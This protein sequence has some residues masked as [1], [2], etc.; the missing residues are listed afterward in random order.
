[1]TSPTS[2]PSQRRQP[3]SAARS[4][5][6]RHWSDA[7]AI[8]VGVT[9]LA[10]SIWPGEPNASREASADLGNA[11]FAHIARLIAG[12]C[13]L[14]GV[15]LAQSPERRGLPRV[16]LVIGALSLLLAFGL[17][18]TDGTTGPR[19]WLSLALP[20]VLLFVASAGVGPLPRHLHD[21]APSDRNDAPSDLRPPVGRGAPDRR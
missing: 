12:A 21:D 4:P 19:A 7:L 20:A 14:L 2:S 6:T 15:G 3:G 18:L 1:M 11:Q 17:A 13:A 8:L 10:L 16:L 5:A 9:L